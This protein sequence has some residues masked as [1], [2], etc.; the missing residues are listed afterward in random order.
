[1]GVLKTDTCQISVTPVPQHRYYSHPTAG[2]I[3]YALPCVYSHPHGG[4]YLHAG[5]LWQRSLT[6]KTQINLLTGMFS[7]LSL[8][9]VLFLELKPQGEEWLKAEVSFPLQIHRVFSIILVTFIIHNCI[10]C[11]QS[12]FTHFIC[13][14]WILSS[15][16]KSFKHFVNASQ[17]ILAKTVSVTAVLSLDVLETWSALESYFSYQSSPLDRPVTFYSRLYCEVLPHRTG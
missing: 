15:W 17:C 8:G 3:L 11:I 7:A 5:V 4:M 2:C 1:M 6:K 12:H 16:F 13:T 10:Y 14:S 9:E